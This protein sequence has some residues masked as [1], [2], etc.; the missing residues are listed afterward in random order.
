LACRYFR[1]ELPS[2][3]AGFSNGETVS[4]TSSIE[5]ARSLSAAST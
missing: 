3:A 2:S 5:R 4:P 1:S